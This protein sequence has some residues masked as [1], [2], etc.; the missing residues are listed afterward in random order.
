MGVNKELLLSTL[1]S[2]HG[3]ATANVVQLVFFAY[4]LL[5]AT[6]DSDTALDYWVLGKPTWICRGSVL[7]CA[8]NLN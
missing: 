3:Y 2:S 1:P 6:A 8:V 5:R 7:F 4:T